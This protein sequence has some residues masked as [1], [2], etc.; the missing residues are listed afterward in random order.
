MKNLALIFFGGGL[1][2][3][4][5]YAVNRWITGAVLS[6]FPY[7]T[8]IVNMT[9]CFLIGFIV[10]Y[11]ERLGTHAMQWRLFL[12]TGLCGGYTTFSSFSLENSQLLSDHRIFIFLVY[13]FGSVVLGLLATY[14]GI[15]AGRS[16]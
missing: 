15:L 6:T 1:G 13:A 4:L 16:L 8:F 7:G 3:L 14:L 10:F 5:R 9:G 11:T 12:V 2:S